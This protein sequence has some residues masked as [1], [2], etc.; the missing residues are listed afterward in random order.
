MQALTPESLKMIDAIAR[1]GSFAKAARE[2]GKVPSAVTY[3]VRKIEEDLDALLFDRSGHR[4]RLTP[5][6]MELLRE[7]RH[8]LAAFDALAQRIRRVATGWEVVLRIAVNTTLCEAPLFDLIEDFHALD[9]GTRLRF[10]HEVLQ[11]NWDALLSGRADL[12][13]GADADGAPAEG[14]QSQALGTMPFVFCVA[15][16]HPLAAAAE[17]L[18]PA[19]LERH[20]AVVVADTSRG[21]PAETKG[22]LSIQ[23]TLTVPDMQTKLDAQLRGLGCGYLPGP[24]AEPYLSQGLLVERRVEGVALNER[25]LYAWRAPAEGLALKWFLERLQSPRLRAAL[26]TRP[27]A[28]AAHSLRRPS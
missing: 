21:L 3:S 10:S 13:L 1:H 25:L 14:F 16:H 12:V 11:G 24:L 27:A 28:L 9:T 22:L 20:M 18:E 23:P 15:P 2:L 26:L 5:A 6:G 8:L 19:E 4:A 17:P 7:G